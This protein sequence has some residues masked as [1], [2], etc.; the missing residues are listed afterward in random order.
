[1]RAPGA[2]RGIPATT[3]DVAAAVLVQLEG[4]D[5]HPGSGEEPPCYFSPA[6]GPTGRIRA[7]TCLGLPSATHASARSQQRPP[8]PSL[9]P[10]R[11]QT[12]APHPGWPPRDL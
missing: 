3:W 6:P 2:T 11:V 7:T 4:Q 10:P 12:C 5:G 1:M 9:Q 8:G